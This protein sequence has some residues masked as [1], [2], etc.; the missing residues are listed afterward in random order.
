MRNENNTTARQQRSFGLD[1]ARSIAIAAVLLCHAGILREALFP[2]IKPLAVADGLLGLYG[3]ELFFVLSGFL[4]GSILL[5][6]VV[7]NPNFRSVGR[8]FA[9]RWLR[10][11]PAYYVMI[12][13]L[14]LFNQAQGIAPAPLWSYIFLVQNYDHGAERF[15]P[16]SW[17]LAIEHWSYLLAPVVVLLPRLFRQQRADNS[18]RI[19]QS[20]I[21]ALL[22]FLALRLCTALLTEETWD[23]GFRKQIH[24]RL[25][26]VF[27]GVLIAHCKQHCQAC[28]Q[29]L[30]SLPLFLFTLGGLLLLI[31]FQAEWMLTHDYP[32]GLNGSLFFKTIHFSLTNFFLAL[33]LPFFAEHSFFPALAAS[34]SRLQRLFSATSR[35]AYCLYLTHLTIY[36]WL[37]P[38]LAVW[39]TNPLPWRLFNLAMGGS[40][41]LALTWAVAVLLHRL[42]EKPG[43]DFRRYF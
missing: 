5:T 41:A 32:K 15:F 35:Y 36:L 37:E 6:E 42:V 24:L 23:I 16:V 7:P 31:G 17:S 14:T 34:S 4:I 33:T 11:L 38:M 25:D 3:V 10:I 18:Y 2:A 19:G 39:R 40:F 1:V 8:F 26:A 13:V 12:L 28:Y 29:R 30:A 20:L 21:F 27:F 43:M 22:F 9:R